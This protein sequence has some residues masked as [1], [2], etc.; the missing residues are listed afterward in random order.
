LAA[1]LGVKRGAVARWEAGTREP[2]LDNYSALAAFAEKKANPLARFFAQRIQGRKVGLKEKRKQAQALRELEA[3]E[4]FAAG[5]DEESRRLLELS[6][7][8]PVTYARQCNQRIEEARKNLKNGA[9]TIKL[10]ELMREG[11]RV[12]ALREARILRM[13]RALVFL[14]RQAEVE[15]ARREKIRTILAAAKVATQRGIQVDPTVIMKEVAEALEGQSA[16]TKRRRG[17]QPIQTG[18]TSPGRLTEIFEHVAI[19]EL[20]GKRP[21]VAAILDALEQIFNPEE[22]PRPTTK[23]EAD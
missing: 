8:D 13:K 12:G 15:T 19:Q 23:N 18:R 10:D 22:K 3:E 20:Q 11:A 16:G 7:L 14:D 2:S 5:G 4:Y 17:N 1:E 9:F 6:R 21:D